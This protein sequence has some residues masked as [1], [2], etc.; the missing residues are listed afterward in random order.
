[1]LLYLMLLELTKLTRAANLPT[2][3]TRPSWWL[4]SHELCPWMSPPHP[5]Q[6][7][8]RMLGKHTWVWKH[9]FNTTAWWSRCKRFLYCGVFFCLKHEKPFLWE[10]R[11]GGALESRVSFEANA[12]KHR[13]CQAVARE[14]PSLA[15]VRTLNR[16]RP[17]CCCRGSQEI[18]PHTGESALSSHLTVS[19]RKEPHS[20]IISSSVMFLL[21]KKMQGS[22]VGKEFSTSSPLRSLHGTEETALRYFSFCLQV[23]FGM[24]PCSRQT[25]SGLKPS[26]SAYLHVCLGKLHTFFRPVS[27]SEKI[28]TPSL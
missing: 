23:F 28:I 2:W 5:S 4:E 7:P 22:R 8:A 13:W 20:W 24:R 9:T 17:F 16:G 25:H 27:S 15:L 11:G 6:P 3:F 1:M 14:S 18:L 10:P 21:K 19:Y 12:C 26:L